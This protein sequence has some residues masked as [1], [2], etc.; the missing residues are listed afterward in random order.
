MEIAEFVASQNYS[1]EVFQAGS[2]LFLK[3]K[4]LERRELYSSA[5]VGLSLKRYDKWKDEFVMKRYRFLSDPTIK[6]G[7]NL[8]LL[9]MLHDGRDEKSKTKATTSLVEETRE[10]Y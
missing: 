7:R 4:E 9:G 1:A 3:R 5:R 10:Q 8:V 2:A 6:K